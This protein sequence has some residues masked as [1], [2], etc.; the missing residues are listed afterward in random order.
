MPLERKEKARQRG[1][2]KAKK[3]ESEKARKRKSE[4]AKKRGSEKARSVRTE[5]LSL[6]GFF[7]LPAFFPVGAL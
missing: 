1:S 7:T 5:G 3:R 6:L 4:K 2:E